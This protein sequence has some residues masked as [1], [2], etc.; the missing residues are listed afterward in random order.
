MQRIPKQ[1]RLAQAHASA[2]ALP[3]IA[4]DKRFYWVLRFLTNM[5]AHRIEPACS[6]RR[7]RATGPGCVPMAAANV[8]REIERESPG[9]W[10]K[11]RALLK[12]LRRERSMRPKTQGDKLSLEFTQ[13]ATN[14]REVK[15]PAFNMSDGTLR[16]L[17]L[18]AAVFQQ[19]RPSVL[20]IEEPE[21]TM[22]PGA[23][24]AV[25]DLLRHAALHAGGRDDPQP[26]R[27][28]RRVD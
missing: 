18:V 15:F 19:S 25:L 27:P 3:L 2:L 4:G 5:Q 14:A 8:L 7:I 21:A 20:I 28:R 22:H 10:Q 24:G 23:L 16:A 11:I 17:G 26:R 9:D 12:A 6:E 13:K 1:C